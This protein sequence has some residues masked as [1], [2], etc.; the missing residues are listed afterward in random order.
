MY[1]ARARAYLS[2]FMEKQ[3]ELF[4]TLRMGGSDAVT[5]FV[6][7]CVNI[8]EAGGGDA[9]SKWVALALPLLPEPERAALV[10]LLMDSLLANYDVEF[11]SYRSNELH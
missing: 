6:E 2:F 3:K 8:H 7:N 9:V 1:A 5:A 11:E 4:N 10:T